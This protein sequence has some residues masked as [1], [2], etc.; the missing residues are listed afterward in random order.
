METLL[1]LV[2]MPQKTGWYMLEK[3]KKTRDYL[4]VFYQR[5]EQWKHWSFC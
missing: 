5:L 2:S 1:E 4:I 3:A